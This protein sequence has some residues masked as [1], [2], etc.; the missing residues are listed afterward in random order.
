MPLSAEN[1]IGR[2]GVRIQRAAFVAQIPFADDQPA[3][4]V[5]DLAFGDQRFVEG[6]G[7]AHLHV[8]FDGAV[9]FACG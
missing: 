5:D 1:H 8:E 3:G 9:A 4:L 6:H 7:F 2:R